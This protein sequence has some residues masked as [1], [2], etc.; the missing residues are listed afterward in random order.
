MTHSAHACIYMYIKFSMIESF[1]VTT[2]SESVE[3]MGCK[4]VVTRIPDHSLLSWE[5]G[6]DCVDEREEEVVESGVEKR[7]RAPEESEAEGV[8]RL[9]D[10]VVA[11]GEDQVV[12]DEVYE[13]LVKMMRGGLV[14]V[15]VRSGKGRQQWFT[16]KIGKLQKAFHGAERE[17]G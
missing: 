13:E 12:I 3:E 11:A 8:R 17:S 7:Y 6:V 9:R 1:K 10:R 14:A 5:I 16:K 4:G 15:K 2:M